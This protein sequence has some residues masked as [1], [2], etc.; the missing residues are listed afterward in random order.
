MIGSYFIEYI[1]SRRGTSTPEVLDRF[2]FWSSE[3]NVRYLRNLA[4]VG[5]RSFYRMDRPISAQIP[6]NGSL[7]RVFPP[8]VRLVDQEGKEICRWTAADE[9]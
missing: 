2:P 1:W 4:H 7:R 8:A 6:I 3:P 9:A 5:I